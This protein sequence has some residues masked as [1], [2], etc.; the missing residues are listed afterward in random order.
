MSLL[1]HLI[2]YGFHDILCFQ[3]GGETL[4]SYYEGSHIKALQSLYPELN[5]KS[6]YF[7]KQS[8]LISMSRIILLILF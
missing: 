6:K 5:M 3:K 7:Q 2:S 8:G 1:L 4:L